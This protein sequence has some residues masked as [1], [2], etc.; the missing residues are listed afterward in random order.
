MVT[1]S[2]LRIALIAALVVAV[3]IVLLRFFAPMFFRP[4]WAAVGILLACFVAYSGMKQHLLRSAMLLIA[5]MLYPFWIA[6][7]VSFA[8]YGWSWSGVAIIVSV[9]LVLAASALL[10]LRQPKSV[11]VAFF[12]WQLMLAVPFDV[13]FATVPDGPKVLPLVMGLLSAEGQAAAERGQFVS[14]GCLVSG[15][16]PE[17][18]LA[19]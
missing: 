1:V 11:V 5:M 3:G 4:L 18:V 7:P 10:V 12:L 19:W 16:E 13:T 9:A 17:W 2:R 6:F 15:L 8:P 14:G